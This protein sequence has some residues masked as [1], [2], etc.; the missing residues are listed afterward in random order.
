MRDMAKGNLKADK[1][2][3]D[4]LEILNFKKELIEKTVFDFNWFSAQFSNCLVIKGVLPK[5]DFK[6]WFHK[7]IRS[8]LFVKN[9]VKFEYNLWAKKH[10]N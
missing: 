10:I 4:V 5:G 1:I 6:N 8:I 3:Q 9:W 2:F 7:F